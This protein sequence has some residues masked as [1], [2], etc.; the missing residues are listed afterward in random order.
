MQRYGTLDHPLWAK[1]LTQDLG[2]CRRAAASI[3]ISLVSR[4]SSIRRRR[5]NQ[6][7]Q[8]R[9]RDAQLLSGARAR[10]GLPG[11]DP[12]VPL[13]SGRP[14]RRGELRVDDRIDPDDRRRLPAGHGH[15]VARRGP[16][17]VVHRRDRVRADFLVCR[18]LAGR[19]VHGDGDLFRVGA[20]AMS[21]RSIAQERRP[22][23]HHHR[24]RLPH[25]DH[26]TLVCPAGARLADRRAYAPSRA[27]SGR[28]RG[29]GSR[30]LGADRRAVSDQL[31]VG[32][33]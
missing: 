11:S 7:H 31:R 23:W 5:S 1:V 12:R 26:G 8:V 29:R 13:A 30:R 33:R 2:A 22:G 27:V 14:G 4:R 3:P 9:A 32:H 24:A 25:A 20:R 6:L 28:G 19:H 15:A 16:G 10:T 18:R 17:A 21:T